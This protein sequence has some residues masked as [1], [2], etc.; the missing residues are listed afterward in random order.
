MV[1]APLMPLLAVLALA[2]FPLVL[3]G[4]ACVVLAV[5]VFRRSRPSWRLPRVWL[6]GIAYLLGETACLLACLGLWLRFPRRLGSPRSQQ[7][8][9]SL[10]RT[11]LGVLLALARFTFRFRLEVHEPVTQP[12]DTERMSGDHPVLVLARHAGPG[13]SFV[14]VH[15]LMSRYR[16]APRIVLT[17][18]L[19]LD[20]AIDVLLS[21]LDCRF[22]PRSGAAA[23]EAIR[24]LAGSL[25]AGDALVLFPE[26]GDWTPTRQRFAVA[27]LRRKGLKVQ[28]QRAAQMVH[29]LPPRPAGTL[30]ALEA[31]P[32]ADVVVFSHTGHDDL[33]DLPTVWNALPLRRALDIIWWREPAEQIPV[34]EAAATEWLFDVWQRIDHWVREQGDLA[35][36]A[37]QASDPVTQP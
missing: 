13:A 11:F 18:R 37:P 36:L 34:G 23:T 2:L 29:V 14:L 27:R 35:A 10:L 3:V 24:S 28:A 33:Q 9:V 26:G 4:H 8:H 15:L 12:A 1:L 31:A 5:L 22:I 30:A 32:H 21:R 7:A 19:R 25:R 6:F 20:P 17:E 16:R